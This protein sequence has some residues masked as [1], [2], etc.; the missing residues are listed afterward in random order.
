V[1]SA[2]SYSVTVT[3]ADGCTGT[4]EIVGVTLRQV[5]KPTIT[6]NNDTLVSTP[7]AGYQW[8]LD[9]VA[10]A[11]ATS[12]EHRATQSGSYQVRITDADGCTAMSDPFVIIGEPV[13]WLDTVSTDVGDRAYLTMHLSPAL[14]QSDG[15]VGYSARIVLNRKSLFVYGAANTFSTTAGAQP[16]VAYQPD[17]TITIEYD[18]QGSTITGAEL[19]RL[20]FEGLATGMPINEVEIR[21]VV[22]KGLGKVPVAGDG[23]VLLSGCDITN[24][25]DFG[26]RVRIE[27]VSPNPVTGEAVVVYRA[28]AGS[29][30][31]LRLSNVAGQAMVEVKLP[32]GTGERQEARVD[33]GQTA[34]GVYML[35]LRDRAE[36]SALPIVITK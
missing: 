36:R 28:P 25:F 17:G 5:A 10:L 8:L 9:S 26:K 27:S 34:S 14:K 29:Q 12:R 30:P 22:L 20:E 16:V 31:A 4:S 33:A 35:E 32:T 3:N 19:F 13:V 6:A 11:G 24:G 2:G 18:N 21:S 1:Q 15:V 7:A 23:L